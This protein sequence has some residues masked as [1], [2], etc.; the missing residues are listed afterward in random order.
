MLLSKKRLQSDQAR[1]RD[2]IRPPRLQAAAFDLREPVGRQ[3]AAL[4]ALFRADWERAT[5]RSRGD[6][7]LTPES[8]LRARIVVEH[9]LAPERAAPLKLLAARYA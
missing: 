6:L 1:R 7:A 4:E 2:K 9:V 5:P 3:A 8:Y